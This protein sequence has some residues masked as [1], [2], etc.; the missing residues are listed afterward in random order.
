MVVEARVLETNKGGL[1]VEINGIRGFM[2]ISQIDRLRVEN[3]EQ[4]VN[5]KLMCMV[6]EVDKEARNLVVSR[7]A[8][9]EKEREEQREKLWAELEVGQ[10]RQGIVGNV[11]DFGAFVDIGGVDGLLHVSEIDRLGAELPTRAKSC[12]WAR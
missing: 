3:V 7:R 8:L 9:L 2:P 11:R 6:T 10:V 4:F 5:Q 1:T 12:R